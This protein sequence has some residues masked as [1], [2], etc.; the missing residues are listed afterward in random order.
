MAG[1]FDCRTEL[2]LRHVCIHSYMYPVVLLYSSLVTESQCNLHTFFLC[3]VVY[4]LVT[5][6]ADSRAFVLSHQWVVIS[7]TWSQHSKWQKLDQ[8]TLFCRATTCTI[9]PGRHRI[10]TEYKL[11]TNCSQYIHS[12]GLCRRLWKLTVLI[13]HS[14]VEPIPSTP[15]TNP[16]RLAADGSIRMPRVVNWVVES[17]SFL[18]KHL[19]RLWENLRLLLHVN[20]KMLY[21]LYMYSSV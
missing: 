12:Q 16:N 18:V 6:D 21:V 13:L 14:S 20:N 10:Q 11:H 8:A 9:I 17:N 7:N 4:T 5:K 1:M 19:P 3:E 2:H 15:I